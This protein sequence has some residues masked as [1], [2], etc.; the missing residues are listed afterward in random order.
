MKKNPFINFFFLFI[1]AFCIFWVIG[2]IL[3]EWREEV[4]FTKVILFF[5]GTSYFLSIAFGFFHFFRK[6]VVYID[7]QGER[8]V[9]FLYSGKEIAVQK[10][11]VEQVIETQNK[12]V[13]QLIS[14]KKLSAYK[15]MPPFPRSY[16]KGL[17]TMVKQV[18]P[19]AISK[20]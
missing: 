9:F 19:G 11:D 14:G 10:R 18:F 13:F 12:Y 3:L 4:S 2:Y 15:Y 8:L 17:D 7:N 6:Q 5:I 16:K 20:S 1:A